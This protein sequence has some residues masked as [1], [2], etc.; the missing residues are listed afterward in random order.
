MNFYDYYSMNP[1]GFIDSFIPYIINDY[2]IYQESINEV[3]QN[4]HSLIPIDMMYYNYNNILKYTPGYINYLE[5]IQIL[6]DYYNNCIDKALKLDRL[7]YKNLPKEPNYDIDNYNGLEKIASIDNLYNSAK[8]CYKGTIWKESVQRYDANILTNISKTRNSIVNGSYKPKPVVEFKQS[9]R[10]H[11]RD[12]KAHHISDRVVQKSLNDN[13]TLP[14][15]NN[16]LIYDNGASQLGKGLSFARKR[17]EIHLREAYKEYG[18]GAY[19]LLIDFSKYFDNIVHSIL[20]DQ[21]STLLSPEELDFIK[22]IIKEFEVDVSYM[23]DDEY[24][25]CMDTIFNS[26]EYSTIS[27]KNNLSK[28]KIMAKSVGIGSQTSQ[29]AGI[30]YPHQLDNWAKIVKSIR[31][32]GRYMDDT[33]IILPSKDIAK[34]IYSEY[35]I[36]ASKLKLFINHKKTR[37]LPITNTICYLKINYTITS[38]TGKLLRK[39]NTDAFRREKRRISKFKHLL[40][41][42][43]INLPDIIDWYRGWRYSYIKYDSKSE[44]YKLD[45]YVAKIF[46]INILAL[47]RK[48]YR[49]N[50]C[51]KDHM[52]ELDIYYITHYKQKT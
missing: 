6:D 38:S 16:L 37:V 15:V 34:Q 1:C 32:Y 23:S 26:L 31:Y 10:G 9:E 19:I 13:I 36:E 44:I 5:D 12:I 51:Y 48:D 28:L 8:K 30:F 43:K 41:N 3:L 2:I 50:I 14:A 21:F 35:C 40:N 20:L 47:T 24:N 46:N 29:I 17:F 18:N 25:N 33:Y 4:I 27:N 11:I 45:R 52:N 42:K 49:Y 22:N 39:V 7:Y